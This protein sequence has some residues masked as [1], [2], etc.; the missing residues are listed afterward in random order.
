MSTYPLIDCY[1]AN[2]LLSWHDR[3]NVTSDGFLTS[4]GVLAE[5]LLDKPYVINLCE[6]RYLFLV[7]FAAALV[8]DQ[9]T[10][11]CPDRAPKTLER[12]VCD[13]SDCYCLTDRGKTVP[14]VE[15]FDI[16]RFDGGECLSP[17]IPS[18]PASRTAVIAF[19]SGSTGRP[20]PHP[21]TWGSLVTVARKTGAALG[22]KDCDAM[23]IVAT[24]PPQHMYGLETSIM[25][26][27]QYGFGIHA[28]R[29]FF[30]EDIRSAL[31][32]IS[33]RR[34]LVTTPLHIR[35]CVS[36]R[37]RLPPIEFILSATAPL[38][39]SLAREAE[40]LFETQVREVY[41]F[42]EAGT[43]ATRRTVGGKQWRVL[44]GLGLQQAAGGCYLHAPYLLEPVLFPDVI[45]P[46]GTCEFSLDGRTS[47][48]VNIGG[49]RASLGDLNHKLN[50]ID[51]VSDG[52]FFTPE[53][54]E[55]QIGRLKAFVVAPGR[56]VRE[57]L[58]ELQTRIDPV[59]MP[60]YL[61]KVDALPRNE[62]G[63]LPR[64]ALLK[65]A[66]AQSRDDGPRSD[67]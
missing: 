52:V 19:T 45:T 67:G 15:C 62:T 5:K 53:D 10:L 4:V 46:D 56:T 12:M 1:G 11:L 40:D 47:D 31:G 20:N 33:C 43:L 61:Y 9:V 57:I 17:P 35:A 8:R 41:G 27:T 49:L 66:A 18:I 28:G 42:T 37:T 48:L 25:L 51:G 22:L 29:P 55:S 60:R 16:C 32:M 38:P 65:L 7:G 3:D 59:F 14:G 21:K 13:Y 26:P 2:H 54:D 63:K 50:E 6:D 44:E 39:V 64:E 30:P 23:G 24:V 58:A 36:E 34:I